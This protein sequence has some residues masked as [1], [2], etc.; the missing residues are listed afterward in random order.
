MKK[1]SRAA[2]MLLMMMLTATTAWAQ[3][4]FSGGAGTQANP[5]EIATVE[6]LIQLSADVNGGTDYG[7]TYFRLTADID[8]HNAVNTAL[9]PTT[10]WNDDT[11]TE[12]NFDA[13]GNYDSEFHG[14]FDGA[15]HTI[16]GIRIYK[17]GK[18]NAD[19]Y[20]GLFGYIYL[21][22]I[23]DVT[24]ADTRITGYYYTGGIVGEARVY[25]YITGCRVAANV[26]IHAVQNS[27]EHGGI[28]GYCYYGYVSHCISEA[29]L[30]GTTGTNF[31]GIAGS[32][33]LGS[34]TDNLAIG[35][36]V[37]AAYENR[38]GA[39]AG[40]F[41][42]GTMQRNYYYACTVAGVA[43]A[44]GVGC[45][46]ADITENDGAINASPSQFS[47]SGTEYTI[48]SA[49]GWN[50][51]CWLIA[52]GESFS[53]KTVKLG[54]DIEVSQCAGSEDKPFRGTFDSKGH[55]LT[56]NYSG[57]ADFIAPFV[58]TAADGSNQPVF[59]NLTV[60]GT[61]STT[62]SYAAGLIGHL[63]GEVTIEHCTSTIDITSAGGSGGFVG[64]CEHTANFTDCAS[65]AVIH[66]AGGNNSGFVGWSRASG[67][68]ITFDGCVFNGKLLQQNGSGGSNGG[69]IGWTGS[70]KTVSFTNCL[71]APAA[72]GTGETMASYNSATF[73]RGW[74]ATTTANHSYYATALGT[75]QGTAPHTIS[76]GTNVTVNAIALIGDA[77]AYSVSG[78][79]AYSGGG[80]SHAGTLYY[81]NDDQVS[82][83][84]TNDPAYPEPGYEYGY[85]ASAGT[86]S[87]TTLTMPDQNVTI[88]Q[89]QSVVIPID[90]EKA[91]A[92][93]ATDPYMIYNKDQLDLLATRVNNGTSYYHNKYFQLG[94][95]IV[96]THTT[97]WNDANSTENNYEAIGGYHN[98][99][100]RSFS[101]NFDGAGHTISG[102]RIYHV[103][104][105]MEH[106]YLG[107][108][109]STNTN[110]HDLTL[111]DARITGHSAVG[112]I[113]GDNN[114]IITR[115]RVA[116][117]VAIHT[118]SNNTVNHGGIAG[119]S[120]GKIT[121]CVSSAALSIADG[122][123]GC[124]YFGG[125]V[126]RQKQNG[127]LGNNLAIG[128]TIPTTS[129]NYRGT[130]CG[131]S[132]E[133][134]QSYLNN[135]FYFGCNVAGVDYATKVGC[136]SKDIILNN[137]ATNASPDQ[138]AVN[139]AH[140]EFTILT[141][142]GWEIFCECLLNSAKWNGFSGNTVKLGDNI[143]ITRMAGSD[144][145]KFGGTFD[146]GSKTL[147]VSYGTET[148]PINEQYAAPLRFV[149]TATV[150]DLHVTGN[151]YTSEK[152][153]A[154]IVAQNSVNLTIENCLSSVTINSS[155]AGDGTHGGF[156]GVT[157]SGSTTT[158][159]G[160]VFN[161]SLLGENTIKCGGF[162][163]WRNGGANI[164]NSIFDPAQVTVS[165]DGSATFARNKVDTYNCFYTYPFFNS[166]YDP[167]YAPYD[168]QD[169]AHP[170][171]Y[172]NG[173][174]ARS[175]TAGENVTVALSGTVTEY[176]QS[177][178]ATEYSVSGITSYGRGILYNNVYYAG[179]GDNVALTLSNT[180]GEEGYAA[181]AGTLS[182]NATDGY[183]LTM[184]DEDVTI[185]L[186]PVAYYLVG[187]MT[188]PAWTP[189]TN[190]SLS[191]NPATPGEYMIQNVP[192][193]K[194]AGIKVVSSTDDVNVQTWYP[195][196]LENEYVTTEEL[197]LYD[198][199]FRPDG[200]GGNDWHYGYFYVQRKTLGD[201]NGNGGIDIGDA[202]CIVNYLVG[203]QN[204]SFY[205]NNA[206]LNGNGGI[207]IGDAV[208]IVNILVGKSFNANANA[209]APA[210]LPVDEPE[211]APA[212]MTNG[213]DP[214]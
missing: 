196:G 174:Q 107:I 12:H 176:N 98:G 43:D 125:I 101:G 110:I 10:A 75:A 147:T 45:K 17:G 26:A 140:N 197:S 21:A 68:K 161:G 158:I 19:C 60:S 93:N 3:S 156:V 153:A 142:K 136:W 73:A 204:A 56:V 48:K 11:S 20:Q 5:Y 146:G 9:R 25:S 95:D 108:F 87:G 185:T 50:V 90:W 154:G 171:K 37:P 89:D 209:A 131:D 135:N 67:W 2:V 133:Y 120:S 28:V 137:G 157:N 83:T 143:S 126:G 144:T 150:K 182:G 14:N 36:T 69:F 1:Y 88:N 27:D 112:G 96:Y 91:N 119:V 210:L 58:L 62:G 61:I 168:P 72:L 38:Y 33:D 70:N 134:N 186:Q 74:N 92:G 79:T 128:V 212:I 39:I 116:P 7:G 66:S 16:S 105:G 100:F 138:F 181:S 141:A 201:V 49:V 175:I 114:G 159:T 187:T 208:V 97:N 211:A 117:N 169:S 121:Y 29:T 173:K 40:K 127:F 6:D 184:P 15:G 18:G 65:S 42:N 149:S 113:A 82:L 54:A 115:C 192:L 195:D 177:G 139:D 160:C 205:E 167:S 86:L 124:T 23:H 53:G 32:T 164:Y 77:T 165:K 129:N 206:D 13:I 152:Y 170:D 151:I 148:N 63:Y 190:Y 57:S 194:G 22:N 207:D 203:K 180:A 118:V 198:I 35:A 213:R 64:L 202:V 214:E 123:S 94:A 78:I 4:T 99:N 106:E 55:T 172:N 84:L 178:T 183:T 199:Y 163:G 76:G 31:G 85:T 200:Q 104:S 193:N 30:S 52:G 24:L 111:A 47:V 51:F 179:N 155:T 34:L 162:I 132:Y 8:F 188:D 189:N 166:S 102:I 191:A 130:I 145:Y 71:Y 44:T 41:Y 103:G 109:G 46:N 80:L 81:G 59:R 122:V